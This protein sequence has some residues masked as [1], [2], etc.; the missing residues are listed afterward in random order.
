MGGTEEE[1]D[2]ALLRFFS[3]CFLEFVDDVG[4]AILNH[5]GLQAR[6]GTVV[7]GFA[8]T[9]TDEHEAGAG[10]ECVAATD[11]ADGGIDHEV[12]AAHR[13]VDRVELIVGLLGGVSFAST[14]GDFALQGLLHL[15]EAHVA[16]A[17]M[18]LRIRYTAVLGDEAVGVGE[19]IVGG[20][21]HRFFA[22]GIGEAWLIFIGY[23]FVEN[24]ARIAE[25]AI[26]FFVVGGFC[27]VDGSNEIDVAAACF[28]IESTSSLQGKG[29]C[30]AL[31]SAHVFAT[32]R[33]VDF[34]QVLG[35]ERGRRDF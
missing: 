1:G 15:L 13:G 19:A 8:S 18:L 28:A 31:D 11:Q 29:I 25:V 4:V 34:R 6:G 5:Q 35:G 17:I 33:L 3:Q 26:K 7:F 30:A 16:V 23:A 12:V 20:F 2:A 14:L 32:V 27:G 24:E 22:L 21:V 9:H 10:F